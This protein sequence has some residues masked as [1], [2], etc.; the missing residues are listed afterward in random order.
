MKHYFLGKRP[1]Y[2]VMLKICKS[3]RLHPITQLLLYLIEHFSNKQI[4]S[5]KI[6]TN[7][8]PNPKKSC[9]C[10][11]EIDP[12]FDLQII[13]PVY[14]VEQYI[15]ECIDSILTQTTHYR[16]I[17]TIINDGSPDNSRNILK[18]YESLDNVIIIDQKNKGLSGARNRALENIYGKYL[19]FVDSDDKL[20]EGAIEVLLN[21]ALSYKADMVEGSMSSFNHKGYKPL[22]TP[23]FGQHLKQLSGF[24][25][26]KLIRSDLMQYIHFPE[27]YW[28]EDTILFFLIFDLAQ[29]MIQIEN[30]IYHY[31]H[32]QQGITSSSKGKPKSLDTFYITEQLLKDRKT[33]RLPFSQSMYEK[34]LCQLRTNFYRTIFLKK[35]QLP[36]FLESCRLKNE[37]FKNLTTTNEK[38]RLLEEALIT[39]NYGKYLDAMI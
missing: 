3:L 2:L 16:Y 4:D 32:N 23:T 11:N 9:L 25:G 37:Y 1:I 24:I 30:N 15:Q 36:I 33:L 22:I 26:G 27:G 20:A 5:Q 28:F 34:F 35:V 38:M 18:Q 39:E 7:I 10:Q 12:K 31:R 19:M 8:H 13:V 14:N 6:L 17:V 21:T 29:N